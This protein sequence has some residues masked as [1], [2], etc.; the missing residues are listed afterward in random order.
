MI[1]YIEW[2]IQ[3]HIFEFMFHLGIVR[4]IFGFATIVHIVASSVALSG[5]RKL[6]LIWWIW[7]K[8]VLWSANEFIIII[9]VRNILANASVHKDSFIF[10]LCCCWCAMSPVITRSIRIYTIF[11]KL[12]NMPLAAYCNSHLPACIHFSTR[13]H[14]QI[15]IFCGWMRLMHSWRHE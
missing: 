15:C 5:W 11:M 9:I 12:K 2:D 8:L 14:D 6:E 4:I 13:L 1:L 3:F 7:C 10:L